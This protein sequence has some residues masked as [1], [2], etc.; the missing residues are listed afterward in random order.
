MRLPRPLRTKAPMLYRWN[1][2][3]GQIANHFYITPNPHGIAIDA[4]GYLFATDATTGRGYYVGYPGSGTPH[5]L[6][7]KRV[8]PVAGLGMISGTH[9]PKQN[10]AK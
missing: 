7:R 8:R 5:E 4:W 2:R 3:T 10:R 1:P 9:F 6:Y